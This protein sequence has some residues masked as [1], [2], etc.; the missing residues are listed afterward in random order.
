M[1]YVVFPTP[2]VRY[3]NAA[4]NPTTD[5]CTHATLWLCFVYMSC[6]EELSGKVTYTM[7]NYDP[8]V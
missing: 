4:C 3:E 7:C 8:I 6:N 2:S 5:R 1:Y